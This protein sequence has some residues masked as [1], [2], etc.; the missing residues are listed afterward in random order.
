MDR[1]DR[2]SLKLLGITILLQVDGY[3]D[4]EYRI[5][6]G[7][8][9]YF[10]VQS[11][12]IGKNIFLK[13]FVRLYRDHQPV[14]IIPEFLSESLVAQVFRIIG[15]NVAVGIIAQDDFS[16]VISHESGGEKQQ[17]Q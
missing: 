1:K 13:K 6:S 11:N 4:A 15:G 3:R 16:S 8:F 10:F 5:H 12:I 17:D 2:D 7:H 14:A 9:F